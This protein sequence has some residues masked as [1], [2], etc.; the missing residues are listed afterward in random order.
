MVN[1]IEFNRYL[2]NIR[3]IENQSKSDLVVLEVLNPFIASWIKTKYSEKIADLFEI[4]TNVKPKIE[5]RIKSKKKQK[6][7]IKE[8]LIQDI[9][10]TKS[11]ILNPAYTFNS[12]IVG[13]SNQFAYT[14]AKSVCE[15]PG[16]LYNPLFIY[17]GVG[18]GKTHLLQS[19]GNIFASQEKV[20]IYVTIEQFLNDFTD[21]LRNKTPDR[22]REKYRNCDLLVI[23]DIQFIS[24]KEKI[25][26]EFFHTFNEL[27]QSKKQ[28]VLAAD[29]EPR[30]IAGLEDRLKSRFVWGQVADIQPPELETKI[31]I[32]KKKC[33]LDFINLSNDVIE[34]IATNMDE[35]IREIEG[36][37]I[38][39]NAFSK[40]IGQQ[41]TLEFTKEVLKEQI[42][43][44]KENITIDQIIEV[45]SKELNVKPSEIK[46]KSRS[47][48]I[49][50]ARRIVI[51]LARNLTPNSMPII[52]NYFGMKDHTAVSHA[53]KKINEIINND[54]NFKVI[55]S[56]LSNK[57][58][59]NE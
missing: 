59:T 56:Q 22:F 55:I 33:E 18:L 27:Y 16:K 35:N 31:A 37:I 20:V 19:I 40:M 29:K 12:F 54:A 38:K 14:V 57:I 43:E 32:I 46:S 58:N 39:L 28:I 44:K 34:Y 24:G 5:I 52:A 13:H 11:T 15:Q 45:V 6:V 42:K 51:Y 30:N 9:K 25:Q 1:E 26:E 7:K 8:G 36:T 21:H 3:Y 4:E 47:Q 23:D 2:K 53:M 49:V 50:N 17:G 48:S 10:L 41:I